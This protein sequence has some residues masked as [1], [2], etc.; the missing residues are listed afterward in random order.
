MAENAG[1][2]PPVKPAAAA[3]RSPGARKERSAIS[4]QRS[5]ISQEERNRQYAKACPELCRRDA[6]EELDRITG[7]TG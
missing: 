2:K 5:A 7:L 6:K 1:S 4:G 3:C